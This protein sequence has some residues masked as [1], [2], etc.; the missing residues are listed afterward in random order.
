M[1]WEDIGSVGEIDVA[2]GQIITLVYL[3]INRAYTPMLNLKAI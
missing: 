2:I 3:V 1:N